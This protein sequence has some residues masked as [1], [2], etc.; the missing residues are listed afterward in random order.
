MRRETSRSTA[1]AVAL[2]C[3]GLLSSTVP[4]VA[5]SSG[6][7]WQALYDARA[8][9]YLNLAVHDHSLGGPGLFT[10]IARMQL[11]VGPLDPG[12]IEGS[13]DFIDARNDTADFGVS[14]LVRILHGYG[15]S[16]LLSP[17]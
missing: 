12:V 11:G 7:D 2:C 15:D 8:R 4:A 16:P 6:T 17:A 5:R 9:E 10:Q 3:A 1:I 14:G 13:L